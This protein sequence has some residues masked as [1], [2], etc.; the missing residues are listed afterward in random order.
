MVYVLVYLNKNSLFLK[1]HYF[2]GEKTQ[3]L[4]NNYSYYSDFFYSTTVFQWN[5]NVWK[6]IINYLYHLYRIKVIF[7]EKFR[8]DLNWMLCFLQKEFTYHWSVVKPWHIRIL[9][10]DPLSLFQAATSLGSYRVSPGSQSGVYS[11][12]TTP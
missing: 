12:K 7:T 10:R 6:Y 9:G 5:P 1:E 4:P 8:N 2:V 3:F 11:V